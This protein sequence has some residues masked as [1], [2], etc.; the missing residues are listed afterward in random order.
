VI[1]VQFRKVDAMN[2]Q[3]AAPRFPDAIVFPDVDAATLSR[4]ETG[5][6]TARAMVQ[7]GGAWQDYLRKFLPQTGRQGEIRPS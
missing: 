5:Y 2:Q 7:D 4:E 1:G 3:N 6:R